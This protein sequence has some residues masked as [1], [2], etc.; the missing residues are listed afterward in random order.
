MIDNFSI[1]MSGSKISIGNTFYSFIMKEF[2][3]SSEDVAVWMWVWPQGYIAFT[4]FF[5][6]LPYCID[7]P[8]FWCS[9]C[10]YYASCSFTSD[11]SFYNLICSYG[12]L[13]GYFIISIVLRMMSG[14]S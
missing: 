14:G 3:G 12:L 7:F 2:W 4:F 5:T 9:D 6:V 1:G 13:C 11:S 8:Y 10:S